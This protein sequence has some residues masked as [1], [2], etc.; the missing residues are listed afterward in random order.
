MRSAPRG[1]RHSPPLVLGLLAVIVLGACGGDGA[2]RAR[3]QPDPRYVRVASFDFPESELLG[4]LFAQALEARGVRV[5]R[6]LGLGSRELVQPALEQGLVDVVPEYLAS[7]LEFVTLGTVTS[8]SAASA[9]DQLRR[10][11][12]GR[13]VS[14]LSYAAA[15]D[16]NALAMKART[17][18]QLGVDTVSELAPIA[19]G[20]DFVGPPEC[21]ERPACLPVLEQK[22]GI[23]FRTFTAVPLD[24][25]TLELQ[26]GEAD[27]G[28]AFSSDPR[29]QEHGLV[30]LRPDKEPPRAENVVPLV[31][32]S[33]LES[34]EGMGP[35]LDAVTASLTTGDLRALNARVAAGVPAATVAREWRRAEGAAAP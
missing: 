9:S 1:W 34:H 11:L 8:G 27:V 35:A 31:R 6:R 22:Y 5:Q 18:S 19:S 3:E 16:R 15:A 17:A 20:L 26:A 33:V 10:A 13:G 7:S 2:S 12:T 32:T 25:I 29:V 23:K 4:E 14:V 24:L 30:L 28:V 21:P